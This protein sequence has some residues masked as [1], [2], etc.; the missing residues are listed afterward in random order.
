LNAERSGFRAVINEIPADHM[1]TVDAEF[2]AHLEAQGFDV[3]QMGL[4]PG[5]ESKLERAL[6]P[7]TKAIDP[8]EYEKDAAVVGETG[9]TDEKAP[10]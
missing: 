7:G 6:A 3:S 1:A 4:A 10:Q 2:Y 8:L 9:S 5:S